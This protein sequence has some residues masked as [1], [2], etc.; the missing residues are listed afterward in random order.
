MPIV[1]RLERRNTKEQMNKGCYHHP[2][3]WSNSNTHP[4]PDAGVRSDEV[5][6]TATKKDFKHWWPKPD[7]EIN[8]QANHRI[9]KLKVPKE[10]V[11]RYYNQVVLKRKQA[12]VLKELSI[13]DFYK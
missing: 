10:A 8:L 7:L 9:V 3:K 4:V 13:A 5:C 11:K 2:S 1:Y 12:V 6:G